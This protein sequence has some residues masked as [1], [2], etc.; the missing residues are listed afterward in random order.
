MAARKQSSSGSKPPPRQK[1][2]PREDPPEPLDAGWF[3]EDEAKTTAVT[4]K[5]A[6]APA[7]TP[8]PAASAASAKKADEGRIKDAKNVGERG[9]ANAARLLPPIPRRATIDVHVDWLEKEAASQTAGRTIPVEPDWLEEDEEE[10][11]VARGRPT[12][13]RGRSPVV[14]PPIPG[15]PPLPKE[16]AG[17]KK[18]KDK[19]QPSR[20]PSGPPPRGKR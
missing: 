7:P 5:P 8:M 2:I 20:R 11:T 3:E 10:P 4:P 15:P 19:D 16:V 14:P 12:P 17:E 13:T 1:P 18:S 9:L 6:P